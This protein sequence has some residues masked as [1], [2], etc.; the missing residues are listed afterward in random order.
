MVVNVLYYS[1]L[2]GVQYATD[3]RWFQYMYILGVN[4]LFQFVGAIVAA[5][6]MIRDQITNF[7][8]CAEIMQG[9]YIRQYFY[10][11]VNLIIIFFQAVSLLQMSNQYYNNTKEHF[12]YKTET[13]I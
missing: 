4:I 5:V 2:E 8:N 7:T 13:E 12:Y 10:T 11:I 1:Y 9:L 6:L 3:Q